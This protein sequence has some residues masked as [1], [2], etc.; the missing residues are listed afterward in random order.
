VHVLQTAPL[1]GKAAALRALVALAQ[2][3]RAVSLRI[4]PCART[5][6]NLHAASAPSDCLALTSDTDSDDAR[7]P[8]PPTASASDASAAPDI[9]AAEKHPHVT[10]ASAAVAA[11]LCRAGTVRALAAL[12]LSPA[13]S[14][15]P[16]SAAPPPS[17]SAASSASAAAASSIGCGLAVAAAGPSPAELARAIV[18]TLGAI[19]TAQ[20][21]SRPVYGR[22]PPAIPSASIGNG[23]GADE[24]E[25]TAWG[26]LLGSPESTD[27]VAPASPAAPGAAALLERVSVLSRAKDPH[28]ARAATLLLGTLAATCSSGW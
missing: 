21:R 2:A 7:R 15:A 10:R 19:A 1:R 16:S 8:G 6:S 25:A 5:C 17:I 14:A 18:Y 9:V 22:P 28:T 24:G 27:P 12:L 26:V 20:H 13:A 4:A 23:L 11:Q 3:L